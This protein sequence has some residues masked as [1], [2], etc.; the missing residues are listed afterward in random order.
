VVNQQLLDYI[1][2]ELQKGLS[3][4]Q[5][6]SAL[7][8]NGWKENDIN[9]GFAALSNPQSLVPQQTV[10][11]LP[12]V[13]VILGQAWLLY[14]QR[15]G[16][17]LGVVAVQMLVIVVAIAIGFGGGMGANLIFKNSM[18]GK[19]GSSITLTILFFIIIFTSQ[20]WGQIA[21]LYAIKDSREGIG[22]VEAYRRGWR[23]ILSYW[24]IMS[25]MGLI[26]VGGFILLI[27]PGIIFSI[28]FSLALF[29][30]IAEDIKGMNALLKSKEYVKGKWWSVL[31]YFTFVSMLVFII[32]FVSSLFFQSL[33]IPLI[34]EIGDFIVW[35][36][37]TPLV[38]T[39]SFLVYSKLRAI[40]GEIIFAPIKGQKATFIILGILGTL[41]IPVILFLF[42]WYNVF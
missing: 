13:T 23:K 8:T 24:W 30:L 27:I 15:W 4:E 10:S 29:V 42:I 22:T 20:A 39:Y 26:I 5:I 36:F 16:T 34:F 11:S 6:K 1:K 38:T 14:K 12:G 28:W 9:E 2:Q 41:L 21:L 31:W 32:V 37:L 40:K 19:I 7:I 3:Q 33:R 35:L 25:L 17:F 18:A